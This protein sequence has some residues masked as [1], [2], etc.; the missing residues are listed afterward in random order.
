[1]WQKACDICGEAFS[2][3]G[4][5]VEHLRGHSE[6][7]DRAQGLPDVEAMEKVRLMARAICRVTPNAFCTRFLTTPCDVSNCQSMAKAHA[8]F[9]ALSRRYNVTLKGE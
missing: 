9:T 1:M 4:R 8:A 2:A 5:Y 6:E 3:P 7:Y